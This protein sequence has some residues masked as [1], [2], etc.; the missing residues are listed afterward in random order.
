MCVNNNLVGN[1]NWSNKMLVAK[2]RVFV[3]VSFR[4]M[5]GCHEKTIAL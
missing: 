4:I 2:L 3:T 1:V 5:T